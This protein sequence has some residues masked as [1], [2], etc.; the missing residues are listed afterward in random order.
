[1]ERR[2]ILVLVLATLLIGRGSG[3]PYGEILR[4]LSGLEHNG[5]F[6]GKDDSPSPSPMPVVGGD[7][8]GASLSGVPSKPKQNSGGP[9]VNLK[10]PQTGDGGG[11]GDVPGGNHREGSVGTGT[12]EDGASDTPGDA[13]GTAQCGPLENSCTVQSRL[14]AC[15]R[16]GNEPSKL[17]LVVKNE[18]DNDLSVSIKVPSSVKID[19]KEL[20]LPKHQLRQVN[21]SLTTQDNVKIVLDAGHGECILG[22]N[23]P[24][25]TWNFFQNIPSYA[26]R[27]TP[28]Y[29]AYILFSTV[30]IVGGIWTCCKFR[31]RSSRVDGG[32]PYQEIEMG[33]P[34]SSSATEVVT[35]DGWD[36]GWDDDWD[37]KPSTGT[38]E[39][40]PVRSISANGLTVRTARGEGWDDDWDD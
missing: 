20:Q 9:P 6:K 40:R 32:V 35:A 13:Q 15:L 14:M 26:I 10:T 11:K 1:M 28:I 18:G 27:M 4:V 29:G 16:P 19:Q 25:P 33:L 17:Y 31:R 7:Q 22:N 12:K 34:Q 24:E 37:D 23:L 2:G 38:S 5:K 21:I 3:S 36:Q 39:I 30:L 8:S